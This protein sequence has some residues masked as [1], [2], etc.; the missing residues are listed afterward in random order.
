MT[1][2]ILQSILII[3]K[4]ID[5]IASKLYT[6][7]SHKI[8]NG[9][10]KTFWQNMAAEERE[11]VLFWKNAIVYSEENT[12]PEIFI[13]EKVVYE[14]L[15]RSK[16]LAIKLLESIEQREDTKSY[17]TT[18]YWMEFYLLYPSLDLIF[19]YMAI[20]SNCRNPETDYE[21]HLLRFVDGFKRFGNVSQEMEL[22]GSLLNSIWK[23]NRELVT[24]SMYDAL[25][26][27]FNRKG[28]NDLMISYSSLAKR[29]NYNNGLLMIDID[30]FKKV[31]D[32]YGHQFG[33]VVLK[34]IADRLSKSLRKSDLLGRFGGEEFIVF[35]TN[36]EN[37]EIKKIAN[38][39]VS[40]ISG[41]EIQNVKVTISIGCCITE[42]QA[43]DENEMISK[44][45][46]CADAK[47][48]NAKNNGKN[49]YEI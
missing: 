8:I 30:N 1:S 49:R 46:S 47:L 24:M 15:K 31:N 5:V 32:T 48:Y 23:R 26:K 36:I 41:S 39:L 2:E 37:E 19:H 25:T 27:V 13:E 20:L 18:A 29:N 44:M 38:K 43:L 42:T 4:E 16:E 14:D 6:K 11:H 3:C 21:K 33:D 17:F 10:E 45:I 7:I 9:E 12:I 35:L 40:V 22:L 28:I 34:E